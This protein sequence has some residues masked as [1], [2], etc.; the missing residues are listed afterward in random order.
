MMGSGELF[1]EA[2]ADE[3]YRVVSDVTSTGQRSDECSRAEWLEAQAPSGQVGSRFRGRNRSGIARWSRVCEVI[4]ADPGRAFAFRTVPERFDL[5]RADS[6]TWRYDLLR[7]DAGTLVRHSYEITQPP[8]QPFRLI[9]GALLP[10]HRDRRPAIQHTLERLAA[11][12][13]AHPT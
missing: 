1:V 2:D 7:Q 8:M 10:H 9:Y 5:S 11:T 3:I 6:T 12:M 4:E 13:G